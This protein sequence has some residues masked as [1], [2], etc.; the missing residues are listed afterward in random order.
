MAD[1]NYRDMVKKHDL[2][3]MQ[4]RIFMFFVGHIG[5][6]FTAHQV[7]QKFHALHPGLSKN[8]IAPR[9]TELR[10]KGLLEYTGEVVMYKYENPLT[11]K[12]TNKK[13]KKVTLFSPDQQ[14]EMK[15]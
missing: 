15:F 8:S 3:K 6:S 5:E 9:I 13:Q 10:Q 1:F 12:I 2:K 14:F 4:E 7:W 11:K